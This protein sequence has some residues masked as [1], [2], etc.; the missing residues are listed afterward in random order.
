MLK[1]FLYRL[2]GADSAIDAWVKDFE[3][4]ERGLVKAQNEVLK[5][6]A[7]L[8]G[9]TSNE[10]KTVRVIAAGIGDPEPT[11]SKSRADYVAQVS[12][13]SEILEPKLLQMIAVVREEMDGLHPKAGGYP[14]GMS[15]FDYDNYLRGTTNAF[16][17]LLDWGDLLKGEHLNNIRINE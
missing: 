7:E 4:L 16:K 8:L 2:V 15:R 10:K 14:A 11:D 6:K 13:F 1:K 17:L 5:L 12:N 9:K 3:S